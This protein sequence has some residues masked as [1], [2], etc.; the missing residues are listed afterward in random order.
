MTGTIHTCV[1]F[2]PNGDFVVNHVRDED[3]AGNVAYNEAYRP[4][5]AYFVDGKHACGGTIDGPRTPF[6]EECERRLR[7][8][9]LPAPV[10][11][12]RPYG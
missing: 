2:Y 3:L 11:D 12:S 4:G 8:M 1:G 6:I 7:S 9:S 5:R 10:M